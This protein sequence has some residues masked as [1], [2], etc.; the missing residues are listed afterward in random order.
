MGY[1]TIA[2]RA[3]GHECNA[4]CRLY[5]DEV[6]HERG[7]PATM[8]L[9]TDNAYLHFGGPKENY[10]PYLVL[11]GHPVG[12]E[13]DFPGNVKRLN[14]DKESDKEPVEYIY[15]LSRK[16][17]ANMCAKGLYEPGFEVPDIIKHNV[18][19]V[20]CNCEMYYADMTFGEGMEAKKSS[21]IFIRPED[22][23]VPEEENSLV[24]GDDDMSVDGKAIVGSGYKIH[25]YFKP[26]LERG[27]EL[28]YDMITEE[29]ISYDDEYIQH[30]EY[31]VA[32]GAPSLDSQYIHGEEEQR[33]L[34]VEKEDE[35]PVYDVDPELYA[36]MKSEADA[37]YQ[38][39]EEERKLA[40]DSKALKDARERREQE[41]FLEE[42]AEQS[43]KP[44]G[45]EPDFIEDEE[46]DSF[47]KERQRRQTA[48]RNNQA[49]NIDSV[50]EL[51][52]SGRD[53]AAGSYDLVDDKLKT[54]AREQLEEAREARD[55][56]KV[57]TEDIPGL[58][59]RNPEATPDV[60]Y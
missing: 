29:M 13:G 23:S 4:L 56:G 11:S 59:E 44:D 5:P 53:V 22:G 41:A 17:L 8:I 57:I 52:M 16:N 3:G 51:F 55:E 58:D 31:E 25:K 33:V 46:S 10:R 32:L 20:P 49:E 27:Q 37:R 35:G 7:V 14:Y 24:C 43:R 2:R 26:V 21:L 47:E 40:A 60:P 18:F 6:K 48:V 45:K 15:E 36:A 9:E 19:Y 54:E 28:G 12:F 30:N 42:E 1:S 50:G 39:R 34:D 38:E